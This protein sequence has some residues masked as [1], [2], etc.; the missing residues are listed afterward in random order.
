MLISYKISPSSALAVLRGCGVMAAL[1]VFLRAHMHAWVGEQSVHGRIT[2]RADKSQTATAA[3]SK[4]LLVVEK[5][6][7]W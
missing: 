3:K 6:G 1:L 4:L 5:F 7:S 2:W